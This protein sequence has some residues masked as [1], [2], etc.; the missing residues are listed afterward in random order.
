[1]IPIALLV[2]REA[3]SIARVL[4]IL[5]TLAGLTLMAR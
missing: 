4:G 1:L 2:F 5:L 3:L